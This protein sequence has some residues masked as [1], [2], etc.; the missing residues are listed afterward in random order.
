MKWGESGC[1]LKQES[2][3]PKGEGFANEV[4]TWRANCIAPAVLLL[5]ELKLDFIQELVD[6]FDT[7]AHVSADFTVL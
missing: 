3:S 2:R 6:G 7:L 1:S 4:Y 5:E